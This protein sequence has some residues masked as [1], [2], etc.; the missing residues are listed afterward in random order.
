MNDKEIE[1][2]QKI[3]RGNSFNLNV[4]D[5]WKDKT[6]YT[7]AGPV[8]DEMQH[9]ILIT[10][11]DDSEFDNVYDYAE[12]QIESLESSLPSCLLLKR[13]DKTLDCGIKA[14]EA[15][16]RWLPTDEKK[17]YQ[18]QIYVMHNKIGYTLTASFSK[19]TKR[20]YGPMVQR[21]MLSFNPAI[22]NEIR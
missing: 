4:Y 10:M 11:D 16:F 5:D 19:V 9:N 6:M 22:T 15:V 21:M 13:G 3:F 2:P 8:S 17:I 1:I 14:Y 18:Q 12:W 20:I 7:I